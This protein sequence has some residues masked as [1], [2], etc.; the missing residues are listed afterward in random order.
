[1]FKAVLLIE[2]SQVYLVYN[3]TAKGARRVIE[4]VEVKDDFSRVDDAFPHD[5]HRALPPHFVAC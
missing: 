2:S 5:S 1:M 4:I 3:L